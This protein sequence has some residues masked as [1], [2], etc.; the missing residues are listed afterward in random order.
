MSL[1]VEIFGQSCVERWMLNGGKCRLSLPLSSFTQGGFSLLTKKGGLLT[2]PF[3]L[4][5]VPRSNMKRQCF[6]SSSLQLFPSKSNKKNP[7]LVDFCFASYFC[8]F[9]HARLSSKFAVKDREKIART[10]LEAL[11]NV[12]QHTEYFPFP[13]FPPLLQQSLGQ[14]GQKPPP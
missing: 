9:S 14:K 13:T 2:S 8:S 1:K 10:D 7:G 12:C 6:F 3:S 5:R 11:L 4:F